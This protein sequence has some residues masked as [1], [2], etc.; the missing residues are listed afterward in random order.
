[1]FFY[2]IL[3]P[4]L[5]LILTSIVGQVFFVAYYFFNLNSTSLFCLLMIA[6]FLSYRP[7]YLF[8]PISVLYAYYALWYLLPLLFAERYRDLPYAS[9][10]VSLSAWMLYTTLTAGAISLALTETYLLNKK[11]FGTALRN[12]NSI[13]HK[14]GI[15]RA[16]KIMLLS[17]M[18]C[19]FSL[20]G[21]VSVTGGIQPWID[22]PGQTFLRRE[23]GG[24]FSVL[25]IF[26]SM[27]YALA[28]GYLVKLKP[29]IWMTFS[30]IVFLFL[31]SPFLGGK[32]QNFFSI[33]FFLAPSIFSSKARGAILFWMILLFVAIF[34]LGIYFRNLS[35]ISVDDLIGYSLNYFNTFEMLIISVADFEPSWFST[36]FLPFNKFLSPFGIREDVFY[37]MSAWL[38]SIYFPE[39]WAIRA[40]QQWPIE[41]DFYMSFYFIGGIPLL[42]AFMIFLQVNFSKAISTRSL[43]FLFIGCH[44]SFNLMSHL[45]GGLIIWNDFYTYP[46]YIVA[47]FLFRNIFVPNNAVIVTNKLSANHLG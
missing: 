2:K 29:S 41:T 30:A 5:I 23:G 6:T 39:D 8:S 16:R 27:F 3:P 35:W 38:T 12:L 25:L 19:I 20:I 26:G 13:V 43:A 24:L 11:I 4:Y 14:R 31:I 17:F 45:R 36:V 18:T 21:L 22:E 1:M 28:A 9:R 15:Q 33:F 32:M 10:I 42:I 44:M 7:R 46:M 47:Y 37:D 34:F 40:T